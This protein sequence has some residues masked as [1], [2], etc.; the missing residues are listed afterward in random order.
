MKKAL[1][2]TQALRAG[3]SKAEP[4]ISPRRRPPSR[5]TQDGQN[6][7]SWRR[8]LPSR[9]D[10]V[11]WRSMHAISPG[12]RLGP[13]RVIT[14][15]NLS[16]M[17]MWDI[18]RSGV[19]TG[20][21]G[22]SMNRGPRATGAPEPQ[23]KFRQSLRKIIKIV[24]TRWRILRLKC[25]KFDFGWG[26][27]PD[28]AVGSLQRSPRPPSWIWETASRQGGGL[29]GGRGGK[30]EGGEVE[31]RERRAPSYCWI[32]APQ[33]LATPLFLRAESPRHS[34]GGIIERQYDDVAK[35]F[36]TYFDKGFLLS[37]DRI[38][39]A[40][41]KTRERLLAAIRITVRTLPPS[42]QV[43]AL[44]TALRDQF[45]CVVLPSSLAAGRG[46]KWSFARSLN[47]S[48]FW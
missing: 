48:V 13:S 1:G 38:S 28:P 4:K 21:S 25:T 20:G 45:F 46:V 43:W 36:R 29:G 3:C 24:A 12:S 23:K 33:S 10:P 19:G 15:K 39:F 35:K 42:A 31:G 18:L 2:E 32:R 37:T 41:G 44:S 47:A 6:I 8:S 22:G 11:W 26:S 16:G 17:L 27:A 9:T 7:I 5:G 14:E 34:S 30:R 40:A